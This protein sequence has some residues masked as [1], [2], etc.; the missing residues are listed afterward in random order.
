M[1]LVSV[2]SIA[3]GFVSITRML[4]MPREM[5]LDLERKAKVAFPETVSTIPRENLEA[6]E[7]TSGLASPPRLSAGAGCLRLRVSLRASLA[8]HLYQLFQ[9]PPLAFIHQSPVVA[10]KIDRG[11][12]VLGKWGANHQYIF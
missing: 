8:G 10:P 1:I 2:R 4:L 3:P 12:S 11:V 7:T 6:G 9:I 5:R